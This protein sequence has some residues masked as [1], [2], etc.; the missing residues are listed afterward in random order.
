MTQNTS[1]TPTDTVTDA[2]APSAVPPAPQ[3]LPSSGRRT[4]VSTYRLQLGPELTFD[5]AI[6]PGPKEWDL[7]IQQFS[8]TDE[9]AEAFYATAEGTRQF[10]ADL[11][12]AREQ[13]SEVP[14]LR[15]L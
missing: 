14:R 4:P 13:E 6:T 5:E 11:H 7:N 1:E 10:A 9:Q 15:A 8:I 3:H 2:T 12:A